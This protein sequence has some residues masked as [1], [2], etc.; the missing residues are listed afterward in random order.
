MKKNIAAQLIIYAA[1]AVLGNAQ[2]VKTEILRTNTVISIPLGQKIECLSAE[3]KYTY[4]YNLSGV[5]IY[6]GPRLK[7]SKD[8][9]EFI[10]AAA[11]IGLEDPQA[12]V[13]GF[14]TYNGSTLPGSWVHSGDNSSLI[15]DGPVSISYQNISGSS[16]EPILFSYKTY[17]SA[18]SNNISATSVVIPS[19]ASGDVDVKMEQSADNVTWTECLPGT[20][21]S[22]TVK[23]FFRLR[24]V[25]K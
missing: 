24:A 3:G 14:M 9:V 19:S 18:S 1:F 25:E 4:D 2:E 22:T 11:P 7:I 23:R 12:V 10:Y 15:I 13:R 16:G 21:N 5:S 17:L 6:K 8:S 20:Y